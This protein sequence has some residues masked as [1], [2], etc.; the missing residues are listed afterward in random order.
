[1][2]KGRVV[3]TLFPNTVTALVGFYLC[4]LQ[5][6]KRLLWRLPK[7]HLTCG[8][9]GQFSRARKTP[10]LGGAWEK[11]PQQSQRALLRK[12]AEFPLPGLNRGGEGCRSSLKLSWLTEMC[13]GDCGEAFLW[14]RLKIST[15]FLHSTLIGKPVS[16]SF[17][18]LLPLR[19]K[20]VSFWHEKTLIYCLHLNMIFLSYL[21]NLRPGDIWLKMCS[22][23]Y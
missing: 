14:T 6:K 16:N 22:P 4:E 11:W 20:R 10:D 13:H 19:S 7:L 18:L 2:W 17:V 8:G 12:P 5:K 23:A 1:M 9:L 3:W 15:I 21:E